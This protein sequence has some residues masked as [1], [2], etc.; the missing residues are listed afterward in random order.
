MRLKPCGL[1]F[2]LRKPQLG[3]TT[4]RHHWKCKCTRVLSMTLF[5]MTRVVYMGVK[6]RNS[7]GTSEGWQPRKAPTRHVQEASELPPCPWS[8]PAGL[9]SQHLPSLLLPERPPAALAASGWD[10]CGLPA[11]ELFSHLLWPLGGTAPQCHAPVPP[12]ANLVRTS[13]HSSVSTPLPGLD[14]C[15]QRALLPIQSLFTA[16]GCS[17]HTFSSDD[18]GG[19]SG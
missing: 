1:R 10:I 9:W 17:F 14:H 5:S 4:K 2:C 19:A 15:K 16:F 13:A 12:P 8:S 7:Q 6:N 11:S 18:S 3:T